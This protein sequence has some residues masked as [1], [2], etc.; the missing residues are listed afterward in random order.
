MNF[1][2]RVAADIKEFLNIDEF[3][4]IH[5]IGDGVNYKECSLVFYSPETPTTEGGTIRSEQ[6]GVI[7]RAEDAPENITTGATIYIDGEGYQII[8][9][10]REEF[11]M[12]EIL[13]KRL[14]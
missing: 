3:A 1:K 12:I 5:E 13:L 9:D 14:Y 8:N 11:G 2:K 10:P 6:S 4:E 7:L